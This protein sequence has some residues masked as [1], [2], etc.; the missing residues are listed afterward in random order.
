MDSAQYSRLDSNSLIWAQQGVPD[1]VLPGL[2]AAGTQHRLNS[3]PRM[4]EFFSHK[5]LQFSPSH[6]CFLQVPAHWMYPSL[7]SQSS[8]VAFGTLTALFGPFQ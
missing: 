7:I 1:S 3:S 2:G 5:L 4:I 6:W 8:S